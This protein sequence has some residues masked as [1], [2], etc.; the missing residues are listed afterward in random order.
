MLVMPGTSKV[1]SLNLYMD[2]SSKNKFAYT[3]TSSPN[4]A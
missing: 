1:A 4:T 2:D 3:H